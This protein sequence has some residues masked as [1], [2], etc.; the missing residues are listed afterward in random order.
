LDPAAPD[1]QARSGTTPADLEAVL[2]ARIE[3]LESAVEAHQNVGQAVGL[4]M[5]IHQIDS[6]KAF[7]A[8]SRVATTSGLKIREIAEALLGISDSSERLQ[9]TQLREPRTGS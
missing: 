4:M 5:G 6:S 8:M 7:A 9:K 2:L 1:H 3:Y